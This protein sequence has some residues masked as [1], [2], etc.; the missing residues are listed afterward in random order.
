MSFL[1]GLAGLAPVAGKVLKGISSLLMGGN[2][3]F[4]K[5]SKVSDKLRASVSWTPIYVMTQGRVTALKTTLRIS[6]APPLVQGTTYS[7]DRDAE[8]APEGSYGIVNVNCGCPGTVANDRMPTE[9][10]VAVVI[11]TGKPAT[12]L[13]PD[14]ASTPQ[15]V[16]LPINWNSSQ[17]TSQ[18]L[19]MTYAGVW[20]D[21]V[22]M[23]DGMRGHLNGYDDHQ[24]FEGGFVNGEF[25]GEKVS[26]VG[27][28]DLILVAYVATDAPPM[29][30][31][32]NA[33]TPSNSTLNFGNIAGN[34][35]IVLEN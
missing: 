5:N 9:F 10:A 32:P 11:K 21:A 15:L 4:D 3:I 27:Q 28:G 35:S 24:K 18:N 1:S 29:Y 31:Y 7:W 2:L 20:G 23:L 34:V 33:W 12:T 17:I 14:D 30:A 26:D 25:P 16:S 13:V 22:E 8:D 6:G 19:S